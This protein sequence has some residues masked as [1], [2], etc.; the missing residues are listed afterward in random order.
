MKNAKPKNANGNR[1][2]LHAAETNQI[3][4][5]PMRQLSL[6]LILLSLRGVSESR[7]SE[8]NSKES[9]S[10]QNSKTPSSESNINSA[11]LRVKNFDQ[12]RKMAERVTRVMEKLAAGEDGLLS[13][14]G[15]SEFWRGEV[16]D[17]A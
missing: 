6:S 8:G 9:Q 11:S 7:S 14:R 16:R 13:L 17:A 4:V 10:L 3:V 15:V 1:K 2:S 12:S 5:S